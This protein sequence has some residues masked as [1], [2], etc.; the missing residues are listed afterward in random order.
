[1]RGQQA[2]QG[3]VT[4]EKNM[5]LLGH[6]LSDYYDSGAKSRQM[7]P[8]PRDRLV[9]AFDDLPP[10]APPPFSRLSVL[11]PTLRTYRAKRELR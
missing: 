1:M 6:E 11:P 9:V 10:R 3:E 4:P 7:P 8:Q 2:R 5:A